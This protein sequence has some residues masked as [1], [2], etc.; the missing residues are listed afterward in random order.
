MQKVFHRFWVL[1]YPDGSYVGLDDASGGYPWKPG[2]LSP[3]LWKFW[4][5]VEE[6]QK[7]SNCFPKENFKVTRLDII[8]NND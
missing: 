1:K 6:A 7:Y 3:S 8:E 5:T 4:S 2:N